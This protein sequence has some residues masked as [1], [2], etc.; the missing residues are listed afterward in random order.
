MTTNWNSN[1]YVQERSVLTL[2][3]F[4]ASVKKV[5][6]YAS[7]Y[8]VDATYLIPNSGVLKIDMTDLVRLASSGYFVIYQ[9]DVDGNTVGSTSPTFWIQRGRINPTR[10][11][12]P[13][14]PLAQASSEA[15]LK[16]MMQLPPSM[17]LKAPDSSLQDTEIIEIITDPQNY[18]RYQ[19]QSGISVG[20]W[21]SPQAFTNVTLSAVLSVGRKVYRILYDGNTIIERTFR[22]LNPCAEHAVV[23][24]QSRF[25]TT[26]QALFELLHPSAKTTEAQSFETV[27]E[28]FDVRKGYE[29]IFTL[30]L[31]NLDRYDLW[32]YGDI[33][34][35]SKAEIEGDGWETVDVLG[36]EFTLPNTDFGELSTLEFEIKYRRYDTI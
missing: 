1:V 20:Q 28:V 22:E 3:A 30:R 31:Q 11:Y 9:L 19:F 15:A 13:R 18:A 4:D 12:I 25:G 35:S 27:G 10:T 33:L 16:A 29:E 5:R 8:G 17:I 23:R 21:D 36:K 26:K 14:S 24:W 7:T 2:S 32:Y 6:I 34:T